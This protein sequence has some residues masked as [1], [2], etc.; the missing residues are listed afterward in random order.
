MYPVL[1]VKLTIIGTGYVG[2]V[3]G[4]CFASKGNQVICLDNNQEKIQK[5]KMGEIPFYEPKLE[6][7]VLTSYKN[8]NL[9]FTLNQQEAVEFADIIFLCLP[10]PPKEDGSSDLS[11]VLKV[12]EEIATFFNS[13]KTVVTK[14]TV[15]VG[16]CDLIREIISKNTKQKFSVVS[17]PEFLREGKAVD[18]FNNP[19]RVVIGASSQTQASPVFELYREFLFD[20]SKILV[21]DTKSS[22]L[23]KYAANAFLAT[24]LA[25]INEIANISTVLGSNVDQIA[26]VMGMD[27][28]IG[29]QFLKPGLG[30]G[31]SCFPKDLLSLLQ[32]SKQAGYEFKLLKAT[33][34]GNLRQ[35]EIFYTTI[36][37]YFLKSGKSK[38]IGV[39]GL[40]FKANTDDLR[41][42]PAVKLVIKLLQNGFQIKAYDPKGMQNFKMLYPQYAHILQ[43]DKYRC[44]ENSEALVIATEWQDF[45]KAD[46]NKIRK[47]FQIKVI[48]DG[49]NLM[50]LKSVQSL[51][52]E[53]FSIGRSL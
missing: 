18:D 15:P 42:S 19:D 13:H 29:N 44:L 38:R 50:D 11:F 17:N 36:Q 6:Q 23:S 24:K 25:F 35:I 20:D 2:L 27:E 45:A 41:E 53:Y 8:G 5:L 21:M 1:F 14:S 7:L 52:L 51:G 31:G 10:T 28:R 48:F 22:E 26:R 4:A 37:E 46:L 39:W 47:Q 3:T 34:E 9:K 12:S 30:F 33:I 32:T 40:T 16:T 43:T 49:R